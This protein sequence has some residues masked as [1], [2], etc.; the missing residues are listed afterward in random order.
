MNINVVNKK[1]F[2]KLM[3]DNN[4]NDTNVEE[5][6]DVFFIS[7]TD[8]DKSSDSRIPYFEND[9]SNVLNLSFDDCE[10]DDQPT[11][12]QIL[13]TKAFSEHQA[14]KL[15]AFIKANKYKSQCIVH[16]MAG[17]SRSSAVALFINDYVGNSY[18]KFMKKHP[19]VRPN[20]HVSRIMNNINYKF[21]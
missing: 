18:S 20:A 14:Q 6:N 11:P 17:I 3:F 21:K 7:I 8:T 5:I 15:Y 2:D 19:H 1:T 16:C 9:H 12:T 13:G 10:Y 4:I